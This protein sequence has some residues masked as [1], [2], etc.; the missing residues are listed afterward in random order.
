MLVA[1]QALPPRDEPLARAERWLTGLLAAI[2]PPADRRLVQSYATWQVMRGLRA[3]AR[4]GQ[5][6]TPAEHAR[7]SI[8]AAVRLLTGSANVKHHPL[9]GRQQARRHR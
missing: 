3:S 6:R 9:K 4:R 2:E 7:N 1:G 5:A 8:R